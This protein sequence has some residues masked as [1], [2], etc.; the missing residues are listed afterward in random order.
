MAHENASKTDEH[1]IRPL[2]EN[3]RNPGKYKFVRRVEN[4]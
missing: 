4:N 3:L 2:S 1:I